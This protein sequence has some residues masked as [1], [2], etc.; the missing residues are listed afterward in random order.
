MRAARRRE[1]PN[2][3]WN[4]L[5]IFSRV[6]CTEQVKGQGVDGVRQ[7]RASASLKK[8]AQVLA[9]AQHLFVF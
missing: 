9:H 5:S 1:V 6:N 8:A 3:S 2:R 7:E 4:T